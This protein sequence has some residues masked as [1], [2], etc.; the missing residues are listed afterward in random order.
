MDTNLLTKNI[1][2]P[3]SN[4]LSKYNGQHILIFG[5]G[6]NQGGV[7]SAKFFA[8]QGAQVRVTDLKT[9]DLLQSSIDQLKTYSNIEYVLGEHRNEDIDWANLIIKNPAV[10]PG[11]PYIEYARKNGKRVEL[12]M[13]IF[14][15]FVKPD[16]IIGVTGTKGKSTTASLIYEVLKAEGKHVVFA[17]NIGI[18]VLDTVPFVKKDTIVV[19]E[20]SSFQLEACKLHQLSPRWAIITNILPDH[21][22][23]YTSMGEYIDAKRAIARFQ[24]DQDYLFLKKDDPITNNLGFMAGLRANVFYFSIND[25]PANFQPQLIGEHNKW[26]IAAALKV[27]QIFHIDSN[28]ALDT[29][30]KFKGV[31]FRTQLI[32]TWNNIKIYND[33]AATGPDAGEQALKALPNSILIAGGMNKNMPYLSYAKAVDDLAKEVYF[34]EGDSTEL[35]KSLIQKKEKIKGT[36]NNLEAILT[37]IKNHAQPGD[38]ILFS[39]AAT[40]FNL[41]QNEFDRGRKFNAAVEQIFT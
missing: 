24:T 5:L 20:M 17:G 36:F 12:D 22:N 30:S 31:E 6:V 33:T 37:D 21:L 32:K 8:S 2:D 40:S 38:T 23:Y 39:P 15:E 34:L 13:G 3:K 25:L 18:S 10:K 16:Q 14:F 4:Q 27:A 7:G 35:I 9:A 19:L 29:L 11:N 28:K 1:F 41:F 26:N